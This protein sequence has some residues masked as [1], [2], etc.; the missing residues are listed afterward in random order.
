MLHALW[1]LP[2]SGLFPCLVPRISP[3]KEEVNNGVTCLFYLY[4][5]SKIYMLH[6]EK[7]AQEEEEIQNGP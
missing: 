7:K 4:A 2:G 3:E 5:E 6:F 1:F